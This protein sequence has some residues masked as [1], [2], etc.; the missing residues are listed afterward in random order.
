MATGAANNTNEH[1]VCWQRAAPVQLRHRS[2][3]KKQNEKKVGFG[4]PSSFLVPVSSLFVRRLFPFLPENG[5]LSHF[6]AAF[7]FLP[8]LDLFAIVWGINT[9]SLLAFLSSARALRIA[10]DLRRR[11]TS[12]AQKKKQKTKTRLQTS[13]PAERRRRAT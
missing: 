2:S 9:S 1:S 6:K 3:G 10:E 8:R 11:R 5:Q 4:F 12:L 7:F 13:L